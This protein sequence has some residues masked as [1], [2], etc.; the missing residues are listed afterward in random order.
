MGAQADQGRVPSNAGTALS[1]PSAQVPESYRVP[2]PPAEGRYPAAPA[3]GDDDELDVAAAE[4]AG[5]RISSKVATRLRVLSNDLR[6]LSARGGSGVADGILSIVTGGLTITLGVLADSDGNDELSTFLYV[7]GGASVGR[8]IIELVVVPD[9]YTPA[10]RYTH[11][12]MTSRQEVQAR[13]QFGEDA[14][15]SLADRNRLARLLDATVS[16]G[17]GVAIIPLYLAPRDF[18]FES[19][20]DYFVVIGAGISVVTGVINLLTRTDA[21]RRWEAYTELRENLEKRD[22]SSA[23]DGLQ[24]GVAPALMPGGAGLALGARF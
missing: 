11:M 2:E 1:P 14:L 20:L 18:S 6:A 10:L 21:E 17:A 24:L 19:P 5:V 8:G 22:Q 13:L 7:F 15:E 23:R 4:Q 3:T 12:P 16:I 9:P